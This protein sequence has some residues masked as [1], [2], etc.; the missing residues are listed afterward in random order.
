MR[1]SYRIGGEVSTFADL[2]KW[3]TLL[4]TAGDIELNLSINP[5]KVKASDKIH[6]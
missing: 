1:G 5:G 2:L 6:Q 4:K 3:D